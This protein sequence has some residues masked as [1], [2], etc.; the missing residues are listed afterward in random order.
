MEGCL[1]CYK[2]VLGAFRMFQCEVDVAEGGEF[3]AHVT[4]TLY[5]ADWPQLFTKVGQACISV[6]CSRNVSKVRCGVCCCS[7]SVK[8]ISLSLFLSLSPSS[9]SFFLTLYTVQ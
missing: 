3:T 7:F 1:E 9:S 6:F 8:I 4:D 5:Y 2:Y